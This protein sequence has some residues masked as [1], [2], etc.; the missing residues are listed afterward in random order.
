VFCRYL[1][2]EDPPADVVA[3]YSA[4]H[5]VGGVEMNGERGVLDLALLRIARVG[6]AF[7]RIADAYAALFARTSLLRR[8]LVLMLAILESGRTAA[9]L[10]A[11]TP[12]S[13]A[14]F[15][16][17]VAVLTLRVALSAFVAAVIL[18]PLAAW[19]AVSRRLVR[20][21]EP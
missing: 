6:P 1:L 19:Y 18:W 10:E 20:T 14:G 12:G 16:L 9:A 7:A 5:D 4:A 3:A 8:K 15:V 17:R 11:I 21:N 13:R 2:G